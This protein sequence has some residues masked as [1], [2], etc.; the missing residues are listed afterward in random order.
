MVD[1]NISYGELYQLLAQLHFVD[2]SSERRWKAFRQDDTDI[3]ILLANRNPDAPARTADVVSVRRH[4]VDNG[5]LDQHE[6]E[7][8]LS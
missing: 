6:F 1:K 7:R 2:V 4:L 3:M 8:L 5:L